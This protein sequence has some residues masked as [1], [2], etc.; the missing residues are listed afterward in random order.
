MDVSVLW[1]I[2]RMDVYIL[3]RKWTSIDPG[4]PGRM[5][6]Y[7]LEIVGFQK[8]SKALQKKGT[9]Q[10]CSLTHITFPFLVETHNVSQNSL[11]WRD[12]NVKAVYIRLR[13][14]AE[15]Y[16]VINNSTE[17]EIV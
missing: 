13:A 10:V 6:D 12:S 3:H 15:D 9:D 16:A 1:P 2:S 7:H 8:A 17:F 4:A 14:I 5:F 11:A